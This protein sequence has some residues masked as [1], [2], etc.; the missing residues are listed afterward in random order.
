M[1]SRLGLFCVYEKTNQ[2]KFWRFAA[3][4]NTAMNKMKQRLFY[5]VLE[6]ALGV[7]LNKI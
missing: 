3:N 7:S 5:N 2:N 1:I 6:M 4:G